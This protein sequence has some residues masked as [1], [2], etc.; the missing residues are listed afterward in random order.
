MSKQSVEDVWAQ[1][2]TKSAPKKQVRKVKPDGK[3]PLGS[4]DEKDVSRYV[5]AGGK[6]GKAEPLQCAGDADT[7]C[8]VE[9]AGMHGRQEFGS[10]PGMYLVRWLMIRMM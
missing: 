7:K 1:L 5:Q 8:R 2:K 3:L 4:R 6:G 10:D 9:C